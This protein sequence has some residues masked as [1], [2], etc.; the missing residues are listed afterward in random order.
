MSD[1][2]ERLREAVNALPKELRR[3]WFVV[4]PPWGKGDWVV[5]GHPDPHLGVMVADTEDFDGE[6]P[7][8]LEAADYIAT[9]NPKAIEALLAEV[10]RLRAE[11]AKAEPVAYL[12]KHTHGQHTLHLVGEDAATAYRDTCVE[13][14]PLY[15]APPAPAQP[16][17]QE[18]VSVRIALD[19]L[20]DADRAELIAELRGSDPA[21]TPPDAAQPEAV[22]DALA[23]IVAILGPTVP[24]CCC[25]GCNHEMSEALRIARAALAGRMT[26]SKE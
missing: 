4:G 12:F 3:Q 9:A 19:H 7:F 11:R 6:H 8:A 26:E 17:A 21:P 22:L 2:V 14:V 5:S 10:E 1:L 15:A 20:T 25:A 16:E 13:M 23:Q 18:T 24:P